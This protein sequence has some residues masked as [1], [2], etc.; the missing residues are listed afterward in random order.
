MNLRKWECDEQCV[1]MGACQLIT[2]T[3]GWAREPIT[4]FSNLRSVPACWLFSSFYVM[5]MFCSFLTEE[6]QYGEAN[7]L[8]EEL[9]TT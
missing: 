5:P 7:F 9:D 4:G 3:E 8:K 1:W 2:W 6:G